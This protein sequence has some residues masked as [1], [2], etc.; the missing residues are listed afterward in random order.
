MGVG[1]VCFGAAL[2]LYQ[3]GSHVTAIFV[4]VIGFL[5]FVFANLPRI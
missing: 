2:Y 1:L 4:A 3:Q 5:A